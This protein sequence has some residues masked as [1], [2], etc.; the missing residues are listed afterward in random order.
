M[1]SSTTP[2]AGE[3]RGPRGDGADGGGVAAAGRAAADA[4]EHRVTSTTRATVNADMTTSTAS[5]IGLES[6]AGAGLAT[7]PDGVPRLLRL[8][9]QRLV[10]GV[11][12]GVADHLRVSVGLVRLVFVLL[13]L[14]AGAGVV[15]YAL[16]WIF[17]PQAAG[18]GG[19]T[20]P[21]AVAPVRR[22]ATAVERRQAIGIGA[23]GIAIVIVALALGAGR[24]AG[25]LAAPLI[26]VAIG[27]AFIWREADDAQRQ[28]WRRTAAGWARPRRGAWWRIAAGVVL[29]VGGLAVFAMAQVDTDSARTAVIAV[30]LTLVGVAVIAIP[31]LTKLLRD[32]TDERRERIRETEKAEVAAHLHDSVL[33]T[34][35]LIQRQPGDAREV[36]RLARAQERDLR[37]W[38]YGPGGY[39]RRGDGERLVGQSAT[40][41]RPG[42]PGE[43]NRPSSRETS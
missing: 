8:T 39:A 43:P 34:L 4:S 40:E 1:T 14:L 19:P 31:W 21:G 15:G 9:D 7:T 35:A 3:R 25:A 42:D 5:A 38:L 32:L 27:T 37:A 20:G 24:W 26:I 22:P 17:V 29:V 30:V 23:V 41:I 2:G 16:L 18:P 28:R 33:Q 11:A 13:A 36:Q 10:A 6:A 12:V